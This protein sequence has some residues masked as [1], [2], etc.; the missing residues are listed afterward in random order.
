MYSTLRH[1][2][3]AEETCRSMSPMIDE[4]SDVEYPRGRRG[5]TEGKK[6]MDSRRAQRDDQEILRE[7]HQTSEHRS[8]SRGTNA[9][10]HS[11]GP[12][13]SDPLSEDQDEWE[14][15]P[16]LRMSPDTRGVGSRPSPAPS[17]PVRDLNEE[18]AAGINDVSEQVDKQKDKM[19]DRCS[20]DPP[21]LLPASVNLPR[22]AQRLIGRE[23][24]VNTGDSS[25]A[26]QTSGVDKAQY[27]QY[28]QD[29]DR[30]LRDLRKTQSEMDVQMRLLHERTVPTIYDSYEV[31]DDPYKNW[32]HRG[33]A[34]GPID[35]DGRPPR[36]KE[37]AIFGV[38]L[39][40]PRRDVA[41]C[42]LARARVDS[43]PPASASVHRGAPRANDE[44]Q[45]FTGR[46][47]E[48]RLGVKDG[49]NSDNT[50]GTELAG[51]GNPVRRRRLLLRSKTVKIVKLSVLTVSKPLITASPPPIIDRSAEQ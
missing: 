27:L 16:A 23:T 20:D 51:T 8:A 36:L 41:R 4:E 33:L 47:R 24:R 49:Q 21:Q 45:S 12:R 37:P 28:I 19:D 1:P 9:P 29:A 22:Y 44:S 17:T 40:E 48:Q 2:V 18:S 25:S 32:G 11:Y 42:P 6:R 35:I 3:A 26:F 7:L 5:K 31:S 13:D 10:L 30:L 50:N 14:Y 43:I 34:G 39:P 38:S 46:G 15:V